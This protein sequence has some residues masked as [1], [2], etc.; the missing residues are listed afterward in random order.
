VLL[1]NEATARSSKRKRG[2]RIFFEM[3][4]RR[5]RTEGYARFP[6]GGAPRVRVGS[7][8]IKVSDRDAL[9][10]TITRYQ[11]YVMSPGGSGP[12]RCEVGLFISQVIKL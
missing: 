1:S 10:D 4:R 7:W 8:V 11:G 9:Q 3:G 12:S 6:G 5:L 2:R